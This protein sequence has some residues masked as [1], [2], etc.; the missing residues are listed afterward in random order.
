MSE[1]YECNIEVQKYLTMVMNRG[2]KPVL[3]KA[4]GVFPL[5]LETLMSVSIIRKSRASGKLVE[6]VVTVFF[7]LKKW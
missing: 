4:I 1:W 2:N 7:A 3:M 6:T 5:T